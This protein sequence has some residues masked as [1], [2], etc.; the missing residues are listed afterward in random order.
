MIGLGLGLSKSSFVPSFKG[1]LQTHTGSVAAYR[2]RR[3]SNTYSGPLVNVRRASDNSQ[4]DIGFTASGNLDVDGLRLHCQGTDGFVAKWY[5]QSGNGRNFAQDTAENQ[6]KIFTSD[7]I[8][9]MTSKSRPSIE[10]SVDS[11][12]MDLG[13]QFT[14][15]SEFFM[16]FVLEDLTNSNSFGVLL[17]QDGSTH[18]RIRILANGKSHLKIN[19]S[20]AIENSG[21][22]SQSPVFYAIQRDSSNA[23]KQFIGATEKASDTNSDDFAVLFRLGINQGTASTHALRAKVSEMIFYNQDMSSSRTAITT[24][25]TEYFL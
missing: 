23:V 10:F 20:S 25:A 13:S 9:T 17:N 19:N 4:A 12:F 11:K 18:N 7:S 1:I 24:D 2:L 15:T 21:V 3:L 8:I 5:D 14:F 22:F 16:H 6:P